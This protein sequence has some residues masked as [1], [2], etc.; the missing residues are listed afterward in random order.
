ML[1]KPGSPVTHVRSRRKWVRTDEGTARDWGG[2]VAHK[3]K[4]YRVRRLYIRSWT[5]ACP[6]AST[7]LHAIYLGCRGNYMRMLCLAD[8]PAYY[9]QAVPLDQPHAILN[10]S[11]HLLSNSG[12]ALKAPLGGQIRFVLLPQ[13]LV[14]HGERVWH[15]VLIHLS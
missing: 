8:P 9:L 11:L 13:L 6:S 15:C 12:T 7:P 5:V 14:I 4:C 1:I 10:L 2:P 3:C